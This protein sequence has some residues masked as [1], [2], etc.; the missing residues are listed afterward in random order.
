MRR[1]LT[2]AL[3]TLTAA[4]VLGGALFTATAYLPQEGQSLYEIPL[5]Q[6]P[7]YQDRS[8][9]TQLA[10]EEAAALATQ[11]LGGDW[12]VPYWNALTDTPAYLVGSGVDVAGGLANDTEA[13]ATARRVIA[14]NRGVFRIDPV[15]LRLN[16]VERGMG[17]VAVHFQQTYAGLDVWEG[18]AHLTFSDAGR[19]FVMGS[20]CYQNIQVDPTPSIP[21]AQAE[22]IAARDIGFNEATDAIQEGTRLLILPVPVSDTEVEYHLVWR[23]RLDMQDPFGIWVTHVDAH[24]GAIVWRFN[25]VHFV[26]FTGDAVHDVEPDSYCSG[27]GEQDLKYL[28]VQIASVGEATTAQD[29]TWRVPYAGTT[30]ATLTSTFYGPYIRVNVVDGTGNASFTTTAT[31]GVPVTID[32][33]D[34]NARRDERDCFDAVND[35]HDFFQPFAPTFGYINT[36]ITCNV[37]VSGTCNAYWNGTINFY[38]AGGGCANTGQIQGVV[39]HEFTH[40]IQNAILGQQGNEGLGE[41]NADIL[42]NLMSQDP[43]IGRGFYLNNCTSGIRNSENT[44]R[45]P[46]D[47]TGAIHHDGQI[48]AGFH[49]DFMELMQGLYGTETGTVMAAERWHYGRVLEHPL[50]QPAQ[51]LATFIADDDD[52][53]LSNG[54]PHYDQLCEAA[55][56]HGFECP[57]ILVGV[58]FDH[59][60]LWSTEI[61]GDR[62]VVAQIWS[63]EAPLVPSLIKLHYQ[64]DGGDL[65]EVAMTATGNP[66]EFHG[67]IPGL[68]QPARVAYYLSA[69]DELSNTGTSPRQAPAVLYTFNVALV[70]DQMEVDTGWVVNLEGTDNATTGIWLRAD[71]VGTGA[72]PEDDHTSVPGTICWVTGNTA[73]GGGIGDN[74]VDGGTTTVYSA[75]YDLT[76]ATAAEVA[77]WRWYSNNQGGDPNNDLWVVQVRNNGGPWVDVEREQNDQ[78]QW[79]LREHDLLGILGGAPGIVQFKFVASD[80]ASGSVV[81]AAVDDFDLMALLDDFSAAPETVQGTLRFALHGSTSNPVV[82]ATE[83][84]FQVPATTD[85]ALTLFDVGGRSVAQLANGSFGPG[86]HTVP[87]D[88]KGNGGQPVAAGVYY[89]RMQAGEYTVTRPVVISR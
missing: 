9:Q 29:G 2:R 24:T 12:R 43:V 84:R 13:E 64:I 83:F 8:A 37:G 63:T 86:I 45:Y 15:D 40:G 7:Y 70:A 62:E 55:T 72:Q 14:D 73:P 25:D 32:F 48:I 52:A 18:R 60:P 47:M 85:V 33:N 35:I 76:D 22:R 57:E 21:Q 79:V 56:N 54:T 39:Q 34:G 61:E 26:D 87:W 19:L 36:R 50:N 44:L 5:R 88:G 66:D 28:R 75:E 53:N 20:E 27:I 46:E 3:C 74:D 4:V 6:I 1:T 68:T 80:L 31:P 89:V 69:E 78:N 59:N 41:G 10:G 71:P 81:E 11:R 51:V 82:G 23:V 38:N 49:W 67:F 42:S 77:Y 65:Q 58:L 17:K 30:P 16:N